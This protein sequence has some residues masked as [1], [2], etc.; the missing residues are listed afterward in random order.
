LLLVFTVKSAHVP[1]I[2]SGESAFFT[3]LGTQVGGKPLNHRFAPAF[4][5]LALF[6]Y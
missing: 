6:D 5:G 2:A 3:K 1:E 4:C